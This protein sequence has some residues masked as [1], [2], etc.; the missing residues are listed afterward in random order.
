[1][2]QLFETLRAV[3]ETGSLSRAAEALHLN[4][5]AVTRQI[6]ALEHELGAVLLTRTSHGVE[7]TPV[8]RKVLEHGRQ[9]LAATAAARRAAE[10]SA[11][12]KGGRLRLACG[13]M[14]MQFA[15]PAVLTEF[16]AARPGLEVDLHTG[17]YQECVDR[18]TSYEVDLAI[19]STP[20]TRTGLKVTP[21]F[22]D[23]VVLAV[24]P[25]STLAGRD[26]IALAELADLPLFV[27]PRQTGWRQ[28]LVRTLA[29]EDISYRLVEHPTV[30]TIKVVLA[31]GMGASLLPL[32]AVA[33]EVARGTLRAVP[34]S[35]W[36]EDGRTIYAITRSEGALPEVARDLMTALRIR[37]EKGQGGGV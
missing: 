17:H 5:P 36:P 32:S 27:L 16:R 1:M 30:E 33:Q 15:L 2:L 28:Q 26:Q 19:V 23:P 7:L 24:S 12:G 29:Q 20:V 34:V 14:L 18:L 22:K 4:Q 31:M 11:P 25:E 10:E 35:N 13:A 8:G 21:L 37:Y 9:A 6:K 3:A